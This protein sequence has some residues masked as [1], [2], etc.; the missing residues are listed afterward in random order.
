M[1]TQAGFLRYL[2]TSL[3]LPVPDP[4]DMDHF[5]EVIS[6]NL[7]SP[8]VVLLDEIGVALQS[9]QEFDQAF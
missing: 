4:C 1:S 8:P 2:L 5:S 9:Y 6:R 3:D 7:H